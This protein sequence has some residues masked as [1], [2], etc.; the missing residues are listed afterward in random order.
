VVDECT[1]DDSLYVIDLF[2]IF[3]IIHI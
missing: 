2:N 1:A 3:N